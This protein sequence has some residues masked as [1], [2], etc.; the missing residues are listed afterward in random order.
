MNQII[1]YKIGI[2]VPI[3]IFSTFFLSGCKETF[4][5]EEI[6][7]LL[8][9]KTSKQGVIGMIDNNFESSSYNMQKV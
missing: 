9:E 5:K 3:L 6:I 8:T 2:I 7:N 4:S 1:Y